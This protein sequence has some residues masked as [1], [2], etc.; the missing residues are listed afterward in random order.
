M[1]GL[2]PFPSTCAQAH[3]P[4]PSQTH[5]SPWCSQPR[6]IPVAAHPQSYY[7]ELNS[8]CS[9]LTRSTSRI[10]HVVEP[11]HR[12]QQRTK[13][14]GIAVFP[15]RGESMRSC[16]RCEVQF[17]HESWT[18]VTL[19]DSGKCEVWL[20]ICA[21]D[22][23]AVDLRCGNLTN[24]NRERPRNSV[25]IASPVASRV[26]ARF[27][28]SST[29]RQPVS[30][31]IC[32]PNSSS[33]SD[34]RSVYSRCSLETIHGWRDSCESCCDSIAIHWLRPNHQTKWYTPQ[35]HMVAGVHHDSVL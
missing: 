32:S 17:N 21:R 9:L 8:L 29:R 28:G 25:L 2:N 14:V 19:I 10:R 22:A 5:P 34:L 26:A 20:R 4:L 6:S 16:I 27:Q 12:S 7:R 33:V 24:P 15:Q 13:L 11:Q 35:R 23:N 3:S 30:M 31:A 1:H 18:T